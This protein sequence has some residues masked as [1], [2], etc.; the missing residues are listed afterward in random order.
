[1]SCDL[2]YSIAY[3]PRYM[4]R[5]ASQRMVTTIL[6]MLP[7]DAAILGDFPYTFLCGLNLFLQ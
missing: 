3:M 5:K 7:L 2:T 1:M 6:T 4:H